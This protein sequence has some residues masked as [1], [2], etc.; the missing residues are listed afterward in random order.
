MNKVANESIESVCG[1]FVM[2]G[3]SQKINYEVKV[4]K[5][6]NF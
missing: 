4:V 1:S 6:S 2:L 5:C 3:K